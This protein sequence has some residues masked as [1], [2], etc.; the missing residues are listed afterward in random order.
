MKIIKRGQETTLTGKC[1]KCG[2]IVEVTEDETTL[3]EIINPKPF[4]PLKTIA[5]VAICPVC[6][7]TRY[8]PV[9][10]TTSK[11]WWGR[12]VDRFSSGD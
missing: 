10:P 2:T 12:L 6:L 5:K 7:G 3:K 8:I 4:T 1:Y 11:K 9:Q